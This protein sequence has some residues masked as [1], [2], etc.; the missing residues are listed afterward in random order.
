MKSITRIV[1]PNLSLLL[2][3][4]LFALVSNGCGR[5]PSAL[6]SVEAAPT[7]ALAVQ[8]GCPPVKIALL[9]DQTESTSWTR[10]QQLTID[11]VSILIELL[12]QCGGEIGVGLIRDQ[13]N[14]SLVR[15]RIEP[16]PVPPAEAKRPRNPF[17]AAQFDASLKAQ[18]KEY[19]EALQKWQGEMEPR[20]EVFQRAVT[21]LLEKAPDA[22]QTDIAGAINRADL[23]L[24]EDDAIWNG[25]P[26]KWAIFSTD[27]QDNVRAP[28]LPLRSNARIVVVNGSAS[29]GLL[30]QYKPSLFESPRAAFDFLVSA[31]APKP[32]IK[33]GN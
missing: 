16:P 27:G 17:K 9:Q 28:L 6:D 14:K 1:S 25:V 19:E 10:T 29:S 18:N 31:E 30:N 26:S 33:G 32:G 13:S 2:A 22:G 4:P 11:D 8:Y 3:I 7:S 21:P 20:I 24:S 12:G 15:L 5:P 23:F